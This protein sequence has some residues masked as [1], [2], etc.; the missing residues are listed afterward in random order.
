VHVACTCSAL[1]ADGGI[2]ISVP[3]SRGGSI[4]RAD[5]NEGGTEVERLLSSSF[6][7]H[8]RWSPEP[9]ADSGASE[10]CDASPFLESREFSHWGCFSLLFCNSAC[11]LVNRGNDVSRIDDYPAR[12][13]R[14]I[15]GETATYRCHTSFSETDSDPSLSLS[16][17]FHERGWSRSWRNFMIDISRMARG[18][19]LP[20]SSTLI[21]LPLLLAPSPLPSRRFSRL[22]SFRPSCELLYRATFSLLRRPNRHRY[23]SAGVNS[24]SLIPRTSRDIF[25]CPV[26]EIRSGGSR[27]PRRHGGETQWKLINSESTR[28]TWRTPLWM[29]VCVCVCVCVWSV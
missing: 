26:S 17:S 29:H 15:S 21:T 12:S 18:H 19:A 8:T 4:G 24:P 14:V 6:Y 20:A 9:P 25:I 22:S 1:R 16:L 27:F 28:C 11:S 2:Y 3:D 13:S 23:R 10:G 7:P 5:R